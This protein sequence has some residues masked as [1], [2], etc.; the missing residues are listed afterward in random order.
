MD[1]LALRY[2]QEVARTMN[3]TEASKR[4]VVAQPAVS[5]T[6]KRLEEEIGYTVFDRVRRSIVLN[7]NGRILLKYTDVVFHALQSAQDE[8]ENYNGTSNRSVSIKLLSGSRIFPDILAQFSRRFPQCQVYV[9][10]SRTES[11]Q[12]D[13]KI[14]STMTPPQEG[15][16]QVLLKERILLVVPLNHRLSERREVSLEELREEKFLSLTKDQALRMITDR[17]CAAH[18]F[19]PKVF[20]EVDNPSFLREILAIGQGVAFI[21][22]L[23]WGEIDRQK[24]RALDVREGNFIRYVNIA[25]NPQKYL[26]TMAD[27]FRRF[28]IQYYRQLQENARKAE[29]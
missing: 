18:G 17:H 29:Q 5:R 15:N 23:S 13:L 11:N 24:T 3:M 20:F 4:L 22:E 2:F 16:G 6:I 12:Y 10:Q 1:L 27:T 21:P 19:E 28:T 25:N 7:E 8:I 14:Y 26:F 9:D